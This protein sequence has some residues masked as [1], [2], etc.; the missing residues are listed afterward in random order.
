MPSNQ[1]RVAVVSPADRQGEF[2]FIKFFWLLIFC[3]YFCLRAGLCDA[4]GQ[5]IRLP[6]FKDNNNY[7]DHINES[8]T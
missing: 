1:K 7:R 3:L 4:F 2:Y 8:F 5:L 6:A